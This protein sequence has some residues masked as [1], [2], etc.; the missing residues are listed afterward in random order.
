MEDLGDPLNLYSYTP[1][2]P[3]ASSFRLVRLL[4]S[5]DSQPIKCTLSEY[6]LDDAPPYTALS[7]TWSPEGGSGYI[8]CDGRLVQGTN[9]LRH[10]L[11]Q[12][13]RSPENY[14][15]LLWVDAICINQ[16]DIGER[17]RQVALMANIY[18]NASLVYVWLG[19]EDQDTKAAFDIFAVTKGL[20]HRRRSR[21]DPLAIAALEEVPASQWTILG[22]LLWKPY[23]RRVWIV[24]EFLLAKNI[25]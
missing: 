7:Y 12:F 8:E 24:Q 11:R 22:K 19:L 15:T 18:S 16:Q 10:F 6:P 3:N 1:L 14:E 5:S 20:G 4:P 9:N 25:I 17:S 21:A 2:D 13:G 23:W